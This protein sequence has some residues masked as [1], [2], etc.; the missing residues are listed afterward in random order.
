MGTSTMSLKKT[1]CPQSKILSPQVICTRYTHKHTHTVPSYWRGH[2]TG[3]FLSG[4]R[5]WQEGRPYLQHRKHTCQR[6][7]SQRS[8][9]VSIFCPLAPSCHFDEHM[10]CSI[11]MG[12][13]GSKMATPMLAKHREPTDQKQ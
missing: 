9:E 5:H 12:S 1:P 3:L 8:E 13:V 11:Q 7:S 6:E 2:Q 10:V 4:T